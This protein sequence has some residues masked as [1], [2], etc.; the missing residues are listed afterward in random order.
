MPTACLPE[1]QLTPNGGGEV[2]NVND[3]SVEVVAG[4]V[5]QVMAKGS[6]KGVGQK[7]KDAAVSAAT[8]LCQGILAIICGGAG[9]RAAEEA[10]KTVEKVKPGD[11]G[12]RR[13]VE[14]VSGMNLRQAGDYFGWKVKEVTKGFG[15]FSKADLIAKGFTKE[16]LMK[17][18]EAYERIAETASKNGFLNESAPGRAQQLRE[19]V[20]NL[21]G[22]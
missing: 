1:A 4:P 3:G 9:A 12:L 18:A 7:L 22:D 17:M 15:D 21:F 8:K 2:L 14:D 20:D 19:I 5:G 11:F 6:G 13:I 16:V 10:K